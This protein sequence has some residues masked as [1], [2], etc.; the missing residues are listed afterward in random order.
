M[1]GSEEGVSFVGTPVCRVGGG[2]GERG[3]EPI[4]NARECLGECGVDFVWDRLLVV[5]VDPCT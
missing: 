5:S 2:V 1:V 3:C 4:L